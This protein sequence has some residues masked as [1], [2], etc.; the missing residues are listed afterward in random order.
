MR[1]SIFIFLMLCPVWMQAQSSE[2][3]PFSGNGTGSPSETKEGKTSNRVRMKE[4][5]LSGIDVSKEEVVYLLAVLNDQGEI[6]E[7]TNIRYK[8]T[9][10]DEVILQ[11]L[12]STVSKQVR[13]NS[14]PDSGLEMVYL[15]YYLHAE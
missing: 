14:K 4:A 10:K 12:I 3:S 2:K 15:T 13:Y 5:D 8:T 6:V 9:L 1:I 7:L 11:Q